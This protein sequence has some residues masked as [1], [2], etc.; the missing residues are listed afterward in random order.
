M[1]TAKE[2]LEKLLEQVKVSDFPQLE[3][4]IRATYMECLLYKGV[5]AKIQ[6]WMEYEKTQGVGN[7]LNKEFFI[8]ERHRLYILVKAYIAAEKYIEAAVLI[9]Q[10]TL[11]AERYGRK[12]ISIKMQLMNGILCDKQ[13]LDGTGYVICAVLTA[14]KNGY[15]RII[16]DEGAALLPIWQKIDWEEVMEQYSGEL[17]EKFAHYLKQVEK[18]LK[19]MSGYYP[20]YLKFNAEEPVLSKTEKM[21]MDLIYSGNSNEKIAMKMDI[22]LSTVK[23]H[24]SNIYKK[25][26]VK[27]RNQAVKKVAEMGWNQ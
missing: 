25:L 24:V 21:V 22:S 7:T 6:Q 15:I 4:N 27:K 1:D 8:S 20:A 9:R 13:E 19:L 2:I 16:A 23:F 17:P 26:G 5:D 18:E 10:L 11:F 3:D 14:A 12:Y